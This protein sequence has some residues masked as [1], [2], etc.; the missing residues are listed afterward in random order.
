MNHLYFQWQ[1]STSFRCESLELKNAHWV[2][3]MVKSSKSCK[4]SVYYIIHFTFIGRFCIIWYSG[5][6]WVS[7]E[8]FARAVARPRAELYGGTGPQL[9]ILNVHTI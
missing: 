8:D 9:T 5:H 1:P 7:D 3:L 4:Y 2:T 6:F